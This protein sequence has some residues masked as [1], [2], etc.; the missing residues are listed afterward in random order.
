MTTIS[1]QEAM[2]RHL[3]EQIQSEEESGLELEFLTY[4][5]LEDLELTEDESEEDQLNRRQT[6]VRF[7]PS[8][9]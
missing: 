6:R 8:C 7:G 4:G 2:V 5:T 1:R 9:N 3:V